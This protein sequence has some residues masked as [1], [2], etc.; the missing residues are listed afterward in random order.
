[1]NKSDLIR[2]LAEKEDL[3]LKN[4]ESAVNTIFKSIEQA[5]AQGDRVEIRGFG[6]FQVKNYEEYD[7]WDRKTGGCCVI[8]GIDF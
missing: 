2:M 5:L 3:T 4:A 1:M 7:G 8:P 6:Y